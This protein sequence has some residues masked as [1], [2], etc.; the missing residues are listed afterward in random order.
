[1]S[2]ASS[3]SS[4]SSSSGSARPPSPPYIDASNLQLTCGGCKQEFEGSIQVVDC[5]S[6]NNQRTVVVVSKCDECQDLLCA[7]CSRVCANQDCLKVCCA[8]RCATICMGDIYTKPRVDCKRVVCRSCIH[9]HHDDRCR[10]CRHAANATLLKQEK[11]GGTSVDCDK[12]GVVLLKKDK[13]GDYCSE[14]VSFYCDSC[15]AKTKCANKK[16]SRQMCSDCVISTMCVCKVCGTASVCSVCSD[17]CNGRCNE[18]VKRVTA[19]LTPSSSTSS[20]SSSACDQCGKAA[21]ITKCSSLSCARWLCKACVSAQAGRCSDCKADNVRCGR[22]RTRGLK[23]FVV[24]STCGMTVCV[25]CSSR[26]KIPAAEAG[27]TTE[28]KECGKTVCGSCPCRCQRRKP[29]M[30]IV[31]TSVPQKK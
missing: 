3:S 22:C 20:P 12:C 31:Y 2:S 13:T 5:W 23:D 30:R 24:C 6:A 18:C 29:T 8:A 27:D 28:V 10:G 7:V 26:C 15:S 17:T 16:C 4:S 14:C 9:K 1:M 25:S 21:C 11:K 19:T